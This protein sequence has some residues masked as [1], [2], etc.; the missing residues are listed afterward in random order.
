MK[1]VTLE[2]AQLLFDLGASVYRHCFR[3]Q[4]KLVPRDFRPGMWAHDATH[5]WGVEEEQSDE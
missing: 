4:W 2:E 1:Q 5:E 3:K